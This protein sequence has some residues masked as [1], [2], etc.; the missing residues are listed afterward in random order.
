MTLQKPLRSLA[1]FFV[2]IL[3]IP[4]TAFSAFFISSENPFFFVRW[5]VGLVFL[6]FIPGYCLV[7]AIFPERQR[8]QLGGIERFCLSIM[9]SLMATLL[10]VLLLNL[11]WSISLFSVLVALSLLIFVSSLVALYRKL[12]C[13]TSHS[14]NSNQKIVDSNRAR[15]YRPKESYV[16]LLTLSGLIAALFLFVIKPLF[17]RSYANYVYAFGMNTKEID[18][19]LL[20][21]GA[22]ALILI[23]KT[24]KKSMHF[25]C[26]VLV[27]A[28]IFVAVKARMY[29]S[30]L[31]PP[32][33][34]GVPGEIGVD[35]WDSLGHMNEVLKYG[36]SGVFE[37]FFLLYQNGEV[38]HLWAGLLAPGYFCLTAA[39]SMV[40]GL[41][42]VQITNAIFLFSVLQTV[43]IYAL[44]KRR[45]GDDAKAVFSAF[46][47]AGGSLSNYL[48]RSSTGRFSPAEVIALTMF[49]FG[50]YLLTL[51][52]FRST[53]SL[54]IWL[55]VLLLNFH[56]V[57]AFLYVVVLFVY[58]V[59]RAKLGLKGVRFFFR[60]VK[61][62]HLWEIGFIATLSAL[63]IAHLYCLWIPRLTAP[64]ELSLHHE[65][66]F[67]FLEY[68]LPTDI[69]PMLDLRTRMIPLSDLLYFFLIFYGLAYSIK[70]GERFFSSWLSSLF[71]VYVFLLIMNP[72]LSSRVFAYLYQAACAAGGSAVVSVF[73]DKPLSSIKET[74]GR[75]LKFGV[76]KSFELRMFSSLLIVFVVLYLAITPV[77]VREDP[78]L[79]VGLPQVSEVYLDAAG[80]AAENF[81]RDAVLVVNNIYVKELALHPMGVFRHMGVNTLLGFHLNL[82][83]YYTISSTYEHVYIL[84][85]NDFP[86]TVNPTMVKEEY[87]LQLETYW[88]KIFSLLLPPS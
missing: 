56:S 60:K 47:I 62:T 54:Q 41:T 75:L 76:K 16:L 59:G 38:V 80:W 23:L 30:A 40:T 48:I 12:M 69:I 85:S 13:T 31:M 24:K 33:A 64:A 8:N 83:D 29:P 88:V 72:V 44:V 77:F 82:S 58:H 1:P 26:Y 3:S 68:S 87:S 10:A 51:E 14:L 49:L 67:R 34:R 22:T 4:L 52:Q 5:L 18:S 7:E 15:M 65:E 57:T 25:L 70:R 79:Y 84:A 45:T 42:S 35:T 28:S 19:L 9:L 46:L 27:A 6:L 37:P 71:F 63:M 2:I 86:L 53:K 78:R 17:S 21:I 50:I 36:H 32:R 61:A 20:L 66:R 11:I 73:I 74:S 39:M 55:I 43:I 81:P